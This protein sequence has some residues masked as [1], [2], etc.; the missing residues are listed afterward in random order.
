MLLQ[1][2]FDIANEAPSNNVV[3]TEVGGPNICRYIIM[4]D[5]IIAV[6]KE[7]IVTLCKLESTFSRLSKA[8][9]LFIFKYFD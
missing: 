3:R 2:P 1:P 6:H 5:I 7:N 4:S 8:K 9:V